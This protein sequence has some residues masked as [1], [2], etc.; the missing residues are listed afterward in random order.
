MLQT[1]VIDTHQAAQYLSSIN[2]LQPSW[3]VFI[4]LFFL[5]SSLLYGISLGRDRI[6]VMMVAIYM[7]L[8]V[9][10]Y[11]PFISEFQASISV[12]DTF[13]LKVS[14]FLGAFILLFF[15]LSQSA[16][17]KAFGA[18]AEQGSFMQ[19]AAFSVL[20]AGL[21]ISVTLSFFPADTS[22]WLS[23]LTRTVFTSDGGKSVW[24]LLPIVA[25]V[26]FGAIRRREA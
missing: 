9:V 26:A 13:A 21:L 1:V 23:P 4:I 2:W 8:A 7:A 6:L 24:A 25:M 18:S 14:V 15:L 16:L 10:K 17:L 3:D 19:V 12:N 20:H 5:V 11:V 22:P